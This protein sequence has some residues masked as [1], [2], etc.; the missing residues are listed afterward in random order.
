MRIASSGAALDGMRLLREVVPNPIKEQ[1]L[2]A[3]THLLV[4]HATH[5][6]SMSNIPSRDQRK[7]MLRAHK[8][9]ERAAFA[10]SLPLPKADLAALFDHLDA[11]LGEAACDH[12]LSLTTAFLTGRGLDV[13]RVSAWLR[14]SGGYCDCE[15]LANVEEKLED[16][17]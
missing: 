6:P 15:V 4:R 14:E 5:T 10:A 7:A 3:G 9:R 13:A 17:S 8:E 1:C 16:V 2:G 12:T 11:R